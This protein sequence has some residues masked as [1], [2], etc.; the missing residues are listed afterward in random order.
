[1]KI[2]D[3]YIQHQGGGTAETA[4]IKPPEDETGY[5]DPGRFGDIPA[6]GFFIRHVKNLEMSNIEIAPMKPD[7]RPAFWFYDARDVSLSHV[8]GLKDTV[9]DS[10]GQS[11]L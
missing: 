6:H 3:V 1:V 8:K 10:V 9:V 7:A 4:A 2:R 5:P 11:T